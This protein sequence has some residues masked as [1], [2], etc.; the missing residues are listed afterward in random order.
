MKNLDGR[1]IIFCLVISFSFST[2]YS[3]G[4]YADSLDY[5]DVFAL[6]EFMQDTEAVYISI[7]QVVSQDE[8][9][10]PAVNV[11]DA[12]SVED[13]PVEINLENPVHKVK[14]ISMDICDED[15]YLALMRCEITERTEGF[16]CRASESGDGCCSVMLFSMGGATAIE[17]GSGPIFTLQYVASEEAPSGECRVL[18]TGNVEATDDYY[19]PLDVISSQGEF[20]FAADGEPVDSDGDGIPD[21][22]D[23]CPD[24][25]NSD[26]ENF[27]QDEFGDACDPDIDND[28]Y[29][30]GDMCPRSNPDTDPALEIVIDDCETGVENSNLGNGCLMSD[31]IDKCLADAENQAIFVHG[32]FVS[33]V[34][35]HTNEWKRGGFITRQEKAA[36][37]RCAA[38]SNLPW[39]Q[40]PWDEE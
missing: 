3:E 19:L 22:E 8:P 20:C 17:E 29:V 23:N 24:S 34:A 4:V 12:S 16:L 27:D 39:I 18:T 31:L 5:S 26:Q 25:P 7:N 32:R 14:S 38:R 21:D 6:S 13:S 36:I 28:G 30:E 40:L 1:L 10:I 9:E 37:Q 15:D 11:F 2:S 35:H 33:C